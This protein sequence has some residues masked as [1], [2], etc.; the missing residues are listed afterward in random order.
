MQVC[1]LAYPKLHPKG[2]GQEGTKA[3]SPARP[4]PSASV[5]QLQSD[6]QEQYDGRPAQFTQLVRIFEND[7]RIRYARSRVAV[8]QVYGNR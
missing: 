8:S 7:Q 4:C 5:Q 6:G 3:E 1:A 2:H